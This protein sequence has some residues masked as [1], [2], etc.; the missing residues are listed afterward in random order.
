MQILT[1]IIEFPMFIL[2]WKNYYKT[3]DCYIIVDSSKINKIVE[4]VNKNM[5]WSSRKTWRG[6]VF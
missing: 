5:N 1:T 4:N 6:S 3:S 2:V